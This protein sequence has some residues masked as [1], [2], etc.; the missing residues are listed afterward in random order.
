M[1]AVQ[2]EFPYPLTQAFFHFKFNW[3]SWGWSLDPQ[4]PAGKSF[5]TELQPHSLSSFSLGSW[6]SSP[7]CGNQSC[8]FLVRGPLPAPGEDCGMERGRAELAPPP[9]G[10]WLLA[11][12][13]C[14][15]NTTKKQIRY[16][17]SRTTKLESIAPGSLR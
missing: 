12:L 15:Q 2:V 1:K 6:E 5:T 17:E 9:P 3:Q 7:S 4:A 10:S 14:T 8:T 11:N 13:G 16:Q